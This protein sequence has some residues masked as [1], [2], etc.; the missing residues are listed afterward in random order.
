MEEQNVALGT[1]GEI[2][3]TSVV[4]F[5][6]IGVFWSRPETLGVEGDD[7]AVRSEVQTLSWKIGSKVSLDVV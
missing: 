3:D 7:N 6:K 4:A 5:E 1:S 2:Q